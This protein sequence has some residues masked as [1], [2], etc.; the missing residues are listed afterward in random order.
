MALQGTKLGFKTDRDLNKDGSKGAG[1]PISVVKDCLIE[2]VFLGLQPTGNEFNILGGNVYPTK[3]GCRKLLINMGVKFDVT[4][5]ITKM[6][7][8][9]TSAVVTS[10]IEWFENGKQN[11]QTVSFP[12]K[13]NAYTSVDA[14]IGKGKR[15]SYAWLLEKL[16]GNEFV[17]GEVDD[18]NFTPHTEIRSENENQDLKD[19]ENQAKK[20]EDLI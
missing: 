8:D 6:T 3:E 9:K 5:E 19:L 17:D 20:T 11:K 15:K 2:A 4:P 10:T 18:V 1:Y 7:Q 14:L 12:L 16:T 13:M